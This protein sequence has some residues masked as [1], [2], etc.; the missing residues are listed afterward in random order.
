LFISDEVM[1]GF[2][3]TWTGQY[4]L[5]GVQPDLMTF[6]KVM[7]GGFPAAA[8]GGRAEL[9]Q[10]LAP[11]GGVYQAG[12]LSGNPVATAAGLTTLRLATDAVYDHLDETSELLRKEVASALSAAGVPHV[13]QHAGNL[14]SVFFVGEGVTAVPD[15][16]T[17]G[18]QLTATYAAFFHAML[19]SRV[20]LPPSAFEGWFLSAAHDDGAMDRIVAALPGAAAAAARI[21]G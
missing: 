8:F 20:Y 3:V 1:T 6:G 2:R 7:G 14:F 15:F 11:V 5:D 10:H 18:K 12:T 19:D 17:A 13:I 9:M 21:S 16:A 4:G